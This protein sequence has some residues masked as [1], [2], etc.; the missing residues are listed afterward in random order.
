MGDQRLFITDRGPCGEHWELVLLDATDALVAQHKGRH[1]QADVRLTQLALDRWWVEAS[2]A[3][4]TLQLFEIKPGSIAVLASSGA[5][6]A[7]PPATCRKSCQ[8]N[9][10][11]PNAPKW[12]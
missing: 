3:G 1:K 4:E 8:P 2:D 5:L 7:R 6:A 9:F 10:P 12:K 11:N